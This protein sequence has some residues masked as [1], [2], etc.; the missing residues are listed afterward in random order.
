[1]PAVTYDVGDSEYGFVGVELSLGNGL[2]PGILR[3]SYGDS[4]SWGEVDDSTGQVAAHV[5]GQYKA[6]QVEVDVRRSQFDRYIAAQPANWRLLP[7]GILVRRRTPALADLTDEI[8]GCRHTDLDTDGSVGQGDG[9]TVKMMFVARG[10][11]WN[12]KLPFP[13][14]RRA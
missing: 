11:L 7:N 14:F 5:R 3:V 2:M 6:K 10:V 12:G 1:M 13:G 9:L 4:L 8:I